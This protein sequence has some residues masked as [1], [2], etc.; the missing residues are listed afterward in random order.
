MRNFLASLYVSIAILSI[1][2]KVDGQ[3]QF[4]AGGL[5]YSVNA[6]KPIAGTALQAKSFNDSGTFEFAAFDAVPNTL[7]PFT[8]TNNVAIGIAQRLV[9][10]D[11]FTTYVTTGAGPS[12]NGPNFGW[13]WNAGGLIPI[14]VKGPWYV[15]PTFRFTKSSVSNG[16]GYQPIIGVLFGWEK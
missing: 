11:K 2:P 16:T 9:I 12:W 8:V 10:A 3:S 7:K 5:S 1:V 13:S 6:D 14:H 15:A 4:Y